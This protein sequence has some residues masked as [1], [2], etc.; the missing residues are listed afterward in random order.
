VVVTVWYPNG[1]SHPA[2]V[3][4]ALIEYPDKTKAQRDMETITRDDAVRPNGEQMA[5]AWPGR[6]KAEVAAL[7]VQD[8][9]NLMPYEVW[10]MGSNGVCRTFGML[11]GAGRTLKG[12]D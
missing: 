6:T 11:D 12:R 4:N 3:R 10:V 1:S 5:W 7:A 2:Y 9:D 8:M